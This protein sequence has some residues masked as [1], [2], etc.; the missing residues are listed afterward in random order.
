MFDVRKQKLI[1]IIKNCN[2]EAE[3]DF[4]YS[5]ITETFQEGVR[6]AKKNAEI[7]KEKQKNPI[8]GKEIRSF[9]DFPGIKYGMMWDA[10]EGYYEIYTVYDLIHTSKYKLLKKKGFGKKRLEQIEQWLAKY[11][12][13]FLEQDIFDIKR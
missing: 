1:K 12:L 7:A 9:S 11:D 10:L 5:L 2:D 13:E 4:L 3:F 8:L 6:L